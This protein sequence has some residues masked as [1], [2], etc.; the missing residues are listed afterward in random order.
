[1]HHKYRR[2]TKLIIMY[3]VLEWYGCSYLY[4][5]TLLIYNCTITNN[6][7]TTYHMVCL[8]QYQSSCCL[9][10][11]S[12]VVPLFWFN[13]FYL[14]P[15]VVPLTMLTC[16]SGVLQSRSAGCPGG[17]ERWEA[18]HSGRHGPGSQPW[19]PHEER[20][21]QDDGEEVRNSRHLGKAFCQPAVSNA[22]C[23]RTVNAGSCSE[24]ESTSYNGLLK[25]LG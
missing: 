23:L 22:L 3:I 25:L 18:G 14:S 19:I 11:S 9:N 24:W 7:E 5:C 21:H 13:P 2:E 16:V 12:G 20:V 4:T 6:L 10:Q 17:D 1:M 8:Q 15:S